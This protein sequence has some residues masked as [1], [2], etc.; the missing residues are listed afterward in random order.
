MKIQRRGWYFSSRIAPEDRRFSGF[1]KIIPV[2]K[3]IA[4][5]AWN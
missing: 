2:I 3:A 4:E 1:V 5:F